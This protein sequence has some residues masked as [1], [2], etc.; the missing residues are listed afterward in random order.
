MGERLALLVLLFSCSMAVH[1]AKWE[2]GVNYFVI[3][4][5]QFTWMPSPGKVEVTEVFSYACP[6]CN[7]FYPIAERLKA[8]LPDGATD[9]KSVV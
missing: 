1:A 8:S 4:P 9:R 2:E 3:E 5:A 6:A 7:A